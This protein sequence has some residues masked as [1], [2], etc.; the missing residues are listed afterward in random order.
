MR[1]FAVALLLPSLSLAQSKFEPNDRKGSAEWVKAM[2][3]NY[4]ANGGNTAAYKAA[5][6][7]IDKQLAKLIG[8]KVEW[9]FEVPGLKPA[10]KGQV[11]LPLPMKETADTIPLHVSNNGTSAGLM[12]AP[13]ESL[14]A[15]KPG[16]IVT[17]TGTV[18]SVF[19]NKEKTP[20]KGDPTTTQD[21]NV[22]I[23]LGNVTVKAKR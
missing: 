18:T 3:D 2:F 16:D 10:P 21:K 11:F 12:L 7:E 22:N 15:L 9:E 14:A 19:R 5:S 1:I 23:Q 8:Q 4:K 6:V 20:P 17:V 13:N